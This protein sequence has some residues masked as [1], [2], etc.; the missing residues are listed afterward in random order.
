MDYIHHE[1]KKGGS[2]KAIAW[3]Y[4]LIF[5]ALIFELYFNLFVPNPDLNLQVYGYYSAIGVFIVT[6]PWSFKWLVDCVSHRAPVYRVLSII[7]FSVV[8]IFCLRSFFVFTLPSIYTSAF[9]TPHYEVHNVVYS[10]S[11][12]E[13]E[14][15]YRVSS[16]FLKN[17]ILS[18]ACISES[19]FEI[20]DPELLFYGNKSIF[21]FKIL[22]IV[23]NEEVKLRLNATNKALK[24]N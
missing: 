13:L 17:T 18:Q 16:K 1:K 15:D 22:K 9:G 7:L 14:C 23:P 24:R 10:D 20:K 8:I 21:G 5:A 2:I 19:L 3:L 4:C 11:Y 6:L 12:S